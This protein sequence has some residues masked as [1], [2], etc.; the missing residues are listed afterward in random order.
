M[1]EYKL[2]SEFKLGD[3]TLKNRVVM[4]PMTRSR[5]EEENKA[6]SLIA[7][8]YEQR[9]EAG[10]IIT[11]GT[12][13]SPNG[14]GYPRIPG[15]FN[16]AQV[17]GWKL[18]TDRIHKAGSKTFIQLMHTGAVSQAGNLT[19]DAKVI[20]PSGKL[21]S[22]QMYVDGKG[23]LDHTV[24]SAMTKEEIKETIQEFI[25]SAKLAI[26]AG[27]DGVEIHG[28]NGYLVEQFINPKANERTDEYGGSNENRCRFATEIAQGMSDAIG[29]E[30]VGIRV[31][32]YGIFNDMAEFEGVDAQFEYLAKELNQIGIAY[33]HVVDHSHLG[34]PEVP[35]K[36]KDI[37][38]DNFK[39]VYILSGGYTKERAEKDLQANK[40][41]LV[42]FGV[43]FIANP[44]LVTRMKKDLALSNPDQS[45]FYTPGAKGY[46][47]YPRA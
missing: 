41:E 14:L 23:M 11:E 36:V 19:K 15:L 24:P 25:N 26:E 12:S 5:A 16:Q 4:A 38:R 33:I 42:A 2:F 20:S 34:A 1:S 9:A 7:E 37:I 10:L 21:V 18:V 43:P 3:I 13:P 46:S 8:Y 30:K 27:F 28:A 29:K 31:S 47:D 44:D 32:P 45:T 40:G 35:Q 22:G 17:E 39:G 6:N